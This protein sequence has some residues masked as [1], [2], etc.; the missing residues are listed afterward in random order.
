MGTVAVGQGSH[1]GRPFWPTV[2]GRNHR[3]AACRSER[4]LLRKATLK[5]DFRPE[6]GSCAPLLPQKGPDLGT[7]FFTPTGC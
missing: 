2:G 4:I 5:C 6:L 3:L 1:Q 7:V